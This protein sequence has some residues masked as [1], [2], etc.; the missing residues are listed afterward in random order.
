MFPDG[1]GTIADD[2]PD[3]CYNIYMKNIQEIKTLYP[4]VDINQDGINDAYREDLPIVER[5]PLAVIIKH[6]TEDLYLM[7]NWKNADWK[8]FLTGGIE[9]GDTLEKTVQKEIHEETGFKNVAKIV[10]LDFTAH[11]LFFHTVKNVNRLAHYHLVFAELANLEQD[12]VSEEEQKIADF[13]WVPKNKVLETIT[14]NAMKSLWN[15][16]LNHGD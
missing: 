8:G 7:A 15:F 10:P 14:R 9:E 13:I 2:G 11:A 5:D 1:S 16:Y 4:D 6:P 12:V 3:F